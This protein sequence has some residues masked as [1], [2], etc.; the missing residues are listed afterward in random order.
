MVIGQIPLRITLLRVVEITPEPDADERQ[1]ILA[2][3][4][5]EEA[6]EQPLSA[7]VEALLPGRGGDEDEP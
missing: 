3:L 2:A 7:W 4:A 1:A 6:R 5:A